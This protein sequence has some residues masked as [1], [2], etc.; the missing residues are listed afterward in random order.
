MTGPSADLAWDAGVRGVFSRTFRFGEWISEPVTPLFESWLLTTMEERLHEIHLAEFGMRAPYP[1]HVVV[2]G[3]YFYSLEFLPVTGAA[4]RRS[5]PT[6]AARLARNPRRASLWIGPFARFGA[7]IF[8]ATWR[9]ELAPA[10]EAAVMDAEEMVEDAGPDAL[11]AMIDRLAGLAGEVFA[12]I[13]VVSGSAYKTEMELARFYARHLG[14]LGGSHLALVTGLTPP[15]PPPPHA[16]STLD[17]W[18]PTRGELAI[19]TA[20]KPA[21]PRDHDDLVRRREAAETAARRELAGSARRLRT[22][23]RLLADAQRYARTREEQ[24]PQLTRPWPV[25]RRAV[26]RL[27][28]MLVTAGVID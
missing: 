18:R 1:R 13:T 26:Q 15:A 8:E 21:T 19:R 11:V 14:R 24:A 7:P 2:N 4:L 23:D 5:L 25:L 3:W 12:S 17:W 27:G 22:F 6:L 9:E 20:T 16:V 28:A 10:Y